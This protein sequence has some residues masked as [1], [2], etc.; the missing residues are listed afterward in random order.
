MRCCAGTRAQPWRFHIVVVMSQINIHPISDSDSASDEA[1]QESPQASHGA[2]G[3]PPAASGY[4]AHN[5]PSPN[6]NSDLD[7]GSSSYASATQSGSPATGSPV[8]GTSTEYDDSLRI[9]DLDTGREFRFQQVAWS[10][11]EHGQTALVT[12]LSACLN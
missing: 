4:P 1:E 8:A 9:K 6:S 11:S 2:V 7:P 3:A 5:I 10:F 12:C